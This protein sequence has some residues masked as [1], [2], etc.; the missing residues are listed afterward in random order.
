MLQYFLKMKFPLLIF[1][2]S[3]IMSCSIKTD[4]SS[5]EDLSISLSGFEGIDLPIL[6]RDLLEA[7]KRLIPKKIQNPDGSYYFTYKKRIGE[8]QLSVEEIEQRISLG[9]DFFKNDREN[10]KKLI[11]K[12][13]NLKIKNK[14]E[15]IDGGA[16]GLW[17]PSKDLIIIDFEVIQ[18]GSQIF[19]EI[20]RHE[21]IHVAQSCFTDSRKNFPQRIGLPL[22]FS[23][24]INLNLSHEIY[25]KNSEELINIEREAYTYSKIDGAAIKLL[26]KFCK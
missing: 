2:I 23:S 9:S 20:L 12:I 1:L 18:M 16:L 19:L 11:T 26:D 6:M 7:D 24:E 14:L 17:I 25:S 21:A 13:N 4:K 5:S 15:N 22:E 10:V 8:D 3:L